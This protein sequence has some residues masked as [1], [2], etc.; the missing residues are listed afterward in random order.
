MEPVAFVL[1]ADYPQRTTFLQ[2]P[3]KTACFSGHRED[4]LPLGETVVGYAATDL[5]KTLLAGCIE[6]AVQDG[7]RYFL[8][9]LAEGVD[10]WA[11]DDLIYRKQH[12]TEVLH[13]IAVEPCLHY[14]ESRRSGREA[15]LHYVEHCEAVIT[16]PYQG[17]FSFLRR[18]DYMLEHSWRLICVIHKTSGGTAY[19]LKRAIRERKENALSRNGGEST[20]DGSGTVCLLSRSSGAAAAVSVPLKKVC[21][22]VSQIEGNAAIHHT[23]KS[24]KMQTKASCLPH[25]KSVQITKNRM[26]SRQHAV[27]FF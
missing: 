24:G 5:L 13:L 2:F 7:Y 12:G 19:T 18:N 1:N 4:A 27:R 26:S 15:M 14:L 17:K 16:M 10:L 3:G 6:Q 25:K 11:A 21:E 22:V 23:T 20:P 9:G 8:D